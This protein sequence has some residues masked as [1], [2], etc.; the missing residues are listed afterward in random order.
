MVYTGRRAVSLLLCAQ[1]SQ[2]LAFQLQNCIRTSRTSVH[3]RE[4]TLLVAESSSAFPVHYEH[5]NL[6][7]VQVNTKFHDRSHLTSVFVAH[8]YELKELKI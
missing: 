6:V 4:S 2:L 1:S 8:I 3:Q 7:S 5:F